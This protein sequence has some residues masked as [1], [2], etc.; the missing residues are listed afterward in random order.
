VTAQDAEAQYD[1]NNAVLEVTAGA[2]GLEASLF[3][4]EIFNM[5]VKYMQSPPF[6]FDVEV[7]ELNPSGTPGGILQAVASVTGNEVFRSVKF[8]CGVHRVQ[9]KGVKSC[10]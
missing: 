9:V 10:S 2:G 4:S 5:Y 3:A 8:E 6:C 7:T 1:S